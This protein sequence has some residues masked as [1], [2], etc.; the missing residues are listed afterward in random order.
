MNLAPEIDVLLMILTRIS[1]FRF[2][3]V[4]SLSPIFRFRVMKVAFGSNV[5]KFHENIVLNL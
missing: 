1:M 5:T 2:K 3:H 4:V